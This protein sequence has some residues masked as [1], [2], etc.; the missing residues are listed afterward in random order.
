MI[1][2]KKIRG[3]NRIFKEIETWKKNNLELDLD[4]LNS[5]KRNYCKIWVSPFADIPITGSEI[6]TPKGKARKKILEGL[7]EIFNHWEKQ[8]KTLN[9][10]YY[11]AIWLF[12]TNLERSQVV[13]SIDGLVD[14]YD[15]TFHRPK[16]QRSMPSQ[17][18]G[19]HSEQLNQFNWIYAL[20][21]GYFTTEDL[22]MEEDEYMTLEDYRST[23]KRYRRKLKENPRTY[24]NSYN[25]GQTHCYKIGTI[26]IGTK[27]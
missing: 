9:K 14:F 17:N 11:L 13:C 15:I 8:L 2:H 20:E 16:K 18:F 23:K 19:K 5:Y 3:H 26:W 6:P 1:K 7:L 22:E 21:E 25:E 27:N 4:Y 12:E 24:N 10:P